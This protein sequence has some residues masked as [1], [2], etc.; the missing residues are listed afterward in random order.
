MMVILKWGWMAWLGAHISIWL[1]LA[2]QCGSEF[3]AVS[4]PG[5]KVQD[6]LLG[7]KSLQH[8]VICTATAKPQEDYAYSPLLSQLTSWHSL[9]IQMT[10]AAVLVSAV[11]CFI[12]VSKT[13]SPP[14]QPVVKNA[15][16]VNCWMVS[17]QSLTFSASD[18]SPIVPEPS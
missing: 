2:G 6:P 14:A 8:I 3:L 16:S 1:L 17:D 4:L 13:H 11:N 12:V 7:Q 9:H 15:A 5:T 10:T 18:P